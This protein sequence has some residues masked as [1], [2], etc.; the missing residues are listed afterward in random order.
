ML[1]FF[2]GL[3]RKF[4]DVAEGSWSGGSPNWVE[5]TWSFPGVNHTV[6]AGRMLAVEVVVGNTADDSMMFAYDTTAL[7]SK[8]EI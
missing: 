1:G 4:E 5:K 8:L 7:R 6:A 2:T 3:H